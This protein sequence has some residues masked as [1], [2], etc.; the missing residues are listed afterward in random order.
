[1]RPMWISSL[2]AKIKKISVPSFVSLW[3]SLGSKKRGSQPRPVNVCAGNGEIVEKHYIFTPKTLLI[4]LFYDLSQKCVDVLAFRLAL[5][6]IF[7]TFT[8][9]LGVDCAGQ[10][11]SGLY[12]PASP[13]GKSR[14]SL[15]CLFSLCFSTDLDYF[16]L[17]LFCAG[18]VLSY[19]D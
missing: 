9:S 18:F 16:Y 6:W 17:Y 19:N 15:G 1:M 13:L 11:P 14:G 12:I 7:G 3:I 2:W 8:A 10:P 4:G 5:F